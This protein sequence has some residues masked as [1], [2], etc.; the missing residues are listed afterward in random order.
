[1]WLQYHSFQSQADLCFPI[2]GP[3][4]AL[5][6][7]PHVHGQQPKRR[8]RTALKAQLVWLQKGSFT[9]ITKVQKSLRIYSYPLLPVVETLPEVFLCHSHS[10]VPLSLYYLWVPLPHSPS[11]AVMCWCCEDLLTLERCPSALLHPRPAPTA[12]KCHS[13][14][15]E[16]K[17]VIWFNQQQLWGLGCSPKAQPMVL[18]LNRLRNKS[19]QPPCALLTVSMFLTDGLVYL[20]VK[21]TSCWT[22]NEG[23]GGRKNGV[24]ERTQDAIYILIMQV[25]DLFSFYF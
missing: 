11:A 25:L 5:F 2:L 18:T 10:L 14:C 17:A 19:F 23:R 8:P 7:V 21:P 9:E 3:V 22:N 12:A 20:T 24:W 16:G 15:Q 6:G 1:M 13:L 4:Q